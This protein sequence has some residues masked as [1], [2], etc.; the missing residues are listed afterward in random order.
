MSMSYDFAQ[1]F[2][3][4]RRSEMHVDSINS[5][6]GQKKGELTLFFHDCM[7]GQF[8]CAV[9]LSAERKRIINIA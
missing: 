1:N 9:K 4:T 2:E 7:R 5:C 6:E 8:S 3:A